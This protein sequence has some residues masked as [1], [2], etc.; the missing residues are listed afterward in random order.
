[1][2]PSVTPR[3]VI[4]TRLPITIPTFRNGFEWLM[5]LKNKVTYKIIRKMLDI[6]RKK[7]PSKKKPILL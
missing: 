2:T 5:N 3:T 6:K 7:A 1:V 4:V